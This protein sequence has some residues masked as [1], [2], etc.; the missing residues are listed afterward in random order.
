MAEAGRP[1]KI[2]SPEHLY[3][4][5]EQYK[6]HVKSN[7]FVIKDWVGGMAKEVIREK[8][9]PL[10]FDDFEVYVWSI[11]VAKGIDHIFCNQK[12]RYKRFLSVCSRIRKEIRAD[13]IAGG[14]AGIYN[15]SI[16]QRLNNL[17]EKT[18]TTVIEQPLFGGDDEKENE[19][20]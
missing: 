12:G 14:M 7:P 15:S 16:T 10:S 3:E 9:K 13:Q 5:F 2:T 11:G 20:E 6:R 18:E 19:D 4:L 8:E 17:V 1:A